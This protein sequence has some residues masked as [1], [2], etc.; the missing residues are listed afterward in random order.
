MAV[1]YGSTSWKGLRFPNVEKLIR[2]YAC[3]SGDWFPSEPLGALF[4]C[5]QGRFIQSQGVPED[6]FSAI[7]LYTS[8]L[9]RKES[10]GPNLKP[11]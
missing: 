10:L 3:F 7:P 6:S 5:L 1:R 4:H 9:L 2:K 11:G 8:R